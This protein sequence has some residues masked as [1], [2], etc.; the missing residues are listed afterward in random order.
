MSVEELIGTD[1]QLLAEAATFRDPYA[2]FFSGRRGSI[3]CTESRIVVD[4]GS[5]TTYILI[6]EV[7]SMEY[8]EPTWSR[9]YLYSGLGALVYGLF[10]G[11][12]EAGLAMMALVVGSVLLATGYWLRTSELTIYT[13]R[14]PYSFTSRGSD[15]EQ[16]AREFW[17]REPVTQSE[18]SSA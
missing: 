2:L 6:D 1:E 10:G 11:G 14:R 7:T 4:D 5:E 17:N 3:G 18:Q 8:E 9:A 13:A 15:I 12:P 16:I